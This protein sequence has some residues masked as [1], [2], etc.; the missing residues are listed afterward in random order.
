MTELLNCPFCGFEDVIPIIPLSG[1]GEDVD[2]K[3]LHIV[4]C[5]DCGA[6]GPT[7]KTE[8][9]AIEAWNRREK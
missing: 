3:Y 6:N 8:A 4:H 7:A 5:T 2:G 9:E 1:F